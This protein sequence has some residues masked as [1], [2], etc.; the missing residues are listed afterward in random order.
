MSMIRRHAVAVLVV[1]ACSLSAASDELQDQ[2]AATDMKDP[3]AVFALAQWCAE[4]NQ[5]SNARKYY[6]VVIRIDP[7][8]FGAREALGQVK[9]G[10][11]WLSARM[12]DGGDK[13]DAPAAGGGPTRKAGGPGPKAADIAWDLTPLKDPKPEFTWID[14]YV[15]RMNSVANDSREMDVSVATMM[16]D[17]HIAV[18]IP[19]LT[20]AML[21]PGWKDLYGASMIA[22]ELQRK[23]DFKT[24][25]ALL[26]FLAKASE[27]CQDEE[28][29]YTF[30][31]VVGGMKDKR[32]VPRLV[33]MLSG[34][35][36]VQSGAKDGLAMLTMLP[37]ADITP[38]SAQKWWDLNHALNDQDIFKEQLQDQDDRVALEAAKALYEHRDHSI[39]PVLA[40]LLGSPDRP[41]R[42]EAIALIQRI[43]GTDWSYKVD[44]D[45]KLWKQR[46]DELLAWWKENEFR[47]T[48]IEDQGKASEPTAQ[49][50]PNV[51]QVRKL[52]SIQGNEAA[53]AEAALIGAGD[54]ALPALLDGLRGGDRIARRKAF[55]V[56]QAI[57]KHDLPYDA[58]ADD[59]TRI[60]QIAAWEAW[61]QEQGHLPGG[62]GAEEAAEDP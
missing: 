25:K 15:N 31:F 60:D 29:L 48:W 18:A 57:T 23:G 2:I 55:S 30:A 44:G 41:V 33:E 49:V 39:V 3:E 61:L 27:R 8:H 5:P 14:T 16:A 45:P 47:H 35:E 36:Y 43:T 12:V 38:E 7:E 28:D 59:Q 22:M 6:N 51:E 42:A 11:R 54:A 56:L 40:K 17:D 46:G 50:D 13:S 9:V 32:I 10:N 4:N 19:R 53:A 20:K 1:I 37:A 52:A 62:A 24:A 34:P 58:A 21:D 26:P